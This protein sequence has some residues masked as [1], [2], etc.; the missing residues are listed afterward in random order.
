MNP[1]TK[2]G[3]VSIVGKTNAGK[4]TLLNNILGQKIAITSRKPQ[5]TRH[6]F[7]G[8]KTE[9][10]NQIIFVDTPGFHSGQKRALNRYMNKVASNAMRGVDI[11]LYVVDS[12]K[13]GEE[14]FSRVQSISEETTIILVVNK[15]DKLE[16][17]NLLLPFIEERSKEDIFS[18]IIPIS[19]LKDIGIDDLLNSICNQLPEGDHLYP[20]DQV[21]DISE[22][23]LASEIIREKCINRLGDELPYRI[24]IS[25]ERFSELN[26]IT[27]IDS[28]IFVEKQSQK[29]MLIGKSGSQLKAIGTSSRKELEKLL[30]TKIMLK[31]WVKVKSGW[32][33]N[34]SLLPSMGYDI[35]K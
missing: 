20:E 18:N 31:T 1:K 15:V 5:T 10:L 22:K 14:D 29:G 13:W 30:D 23:F 7:L 21:T 19:A 12:L 4:S 3:Y 26:G 17:K 24:S 33:D 25:I 32:S 35:D 16:E 34:E 2:S 28:A 6:R 9:G 11:V 27:H 8:I